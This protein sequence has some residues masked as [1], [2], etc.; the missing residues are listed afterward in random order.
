MSER[1][2]T[3]AIEALDKDRQAVG[4]SVNMI[5]HILYDYIPR[6]CQREAEHKLFDEM[7]IS[8]TELTSNMMRKEY[9]QWKKLEFNAL[10]L[11]PSTGVQP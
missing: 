3:P 4:M 1:T 9:E 7:F 8:G 2:T 5:M 11:K 10:M 6:A